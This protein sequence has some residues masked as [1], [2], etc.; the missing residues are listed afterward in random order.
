ADRAA[1]AVVAEAAHVRPH[2]DRLGRVEEHAERLVIG[3]VLQQL[4]LVVLLGDHPLE[5]VL[6]QQRNPVDRADGGAVDAGDAAGVAV[7]RATGDLDLAPARRVHRVVPRLARVLQEG[8]A[9]QHGAVLPAFGGGRLVG[10]GLVLGREQPRAGVGQ[11]FGDVRLLLLVHPADVV[12]GGERTGDVV[13]E[14]RADG[15]AGYPA[16]DLAA[17]ETLDVHVVGGARARLP[18]RVL[19]LERLDVGLVVVEPARIHRV[20][21]QYRDRRGVVEHHAHGDRVLAVL[22]QLG[23]VGG[24]TLVR[25]DQAA[26]Y[27]HVEADA[28]DALGDAHHAHGRV[29]VPLLRPVCARPAAPQVD[30]GCAVEDY[31]AGGAELFLDA[32][33]LGEGL[34]HRREALVAG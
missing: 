33:I 7:A 18:Q 10:H 34:E 12:F 26:V 25:I 27:R 5:L 29:L 2:V 15:H 9:A 23:P 28:G 4:D 32:E 30:H 17:Q 11:H 31:R 1:E 24:D 16:Q 6:R 21:G 8:E 3:A 20:V 19:H 22:R 14:E 13:L